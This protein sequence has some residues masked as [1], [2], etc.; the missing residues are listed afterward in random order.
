[1]KCFDLFLIEKAERQQQQEKTDKGLKYVILFHS[2]FSHSCYEFTEKQY[3]MERL[4]TME[5]SI[6]NSIKAPVQPIMQ[7]SAQSGNQF[8]VFNQ[9]VQA[10]PGQ[11]VQHT[12]NN[13]IQPMM[14]PQHFI[15]GQQQLAMS[16]AIRSNKPTNKNKLL[17]WIAQRNNFLA[18]TN[19]FIAYNVEEE[20]DE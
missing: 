8:S 2:F 17:A 11:Q 18:Q 9:Q 6:Q 10:F 16:K 3:M 1:M 14:G 15:L 5:S 7:Q 4:A 20:A 19:A 12:Y 13:S